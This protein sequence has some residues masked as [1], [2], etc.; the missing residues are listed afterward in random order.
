ME[1]LGLSEATMRVRRGLKWHR[2]P[3]DILPA[4]VAD[5]DFDV[6]EPVQAAIQRVVEQ[7]DY[8]YTWREGEASLEVAF[9]ERMQARFSWTVDPARVQ[10]VVD[11]NQA[12]TALILAFSEPGDGVVAQTPLYHPFLQTILGCG[13]RVI[14]NPLRDD[15]ERLVLDVN[16]LERVARPPARILLICNPHNPSGRV[17]EREELQAIGRAAVANDLI[18]ICDEIHADL[19]Y[20][21][22]RHIPIATLSDEIAARTIT[23]TSATKSF[24]IPGL[25]CGVMH[26][27]SPELQARF[28]RAIPSR[29][30]GHPS[31]IG[32]DATIAAWRQGQP[33][34]E[35]VMRQLTINRDLVAAW[36]ASIP[37]LRHH[38]PEATF[39]A[40]LDLSELELPGS[41]AHELFLQRA[42]VALNAGQDFDVSGRHQ[43]VR[44]NFATSSRI[45]NQMLDRMTEALRS[46]TDP[47]LSN[48][49]SPLGVRS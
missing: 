18:V 2:Y 13:R 17:L 44:L 20:E 6:A 40:W 31:G 24:N 42:R 47:H 34:L 48:S 32:I 11:L 35:S 3:D 26:F 5:M 12:V 23:I 22:H 8:G 4:W 1:E 9:A 39:L 29:L 49:E 21:P 36:A 25:R 30:L 19:V 41:S 33:W 7:R 37:S 15:G 45:L 38:P 10:P 28:S 27:G 14:P 46:P 43:C 16:G